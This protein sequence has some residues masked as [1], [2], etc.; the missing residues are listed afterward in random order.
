M[1]DK[2]RSRYFLCTTQPKSLSLVGAGLYEGWTRDGIWLP[3][4]DGRTNLPM[5][6]RSN[7]AL[8]YIENAAETP[9]NN[10]NFVCIL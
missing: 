5:D 6:R 1:P 8:R 4:T 3:R 7:V 2:K 10:T 9:A